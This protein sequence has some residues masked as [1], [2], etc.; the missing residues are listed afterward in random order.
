METDTAAP[1]QA[2]QTD[3]STAE[4]NIS[5][6][7]PKL[8][9]VDAK[10]SDTEGK[11]E[12]NLAIYQFQQAQDEAK[13]APQLNV[14]KWE[15]SP[16][17]QNAKLSKTGMAM[18]FALLVASL[19]GPL[20]MRT[21]AK[22]AM[23]A[24]TAAIKGWTEGDKEKWETARSDYD[25]HLKFIEDQNKQLVAAEKQIRADKALNYHEKDTQ[26]RLLLLSYGVDRRQLDGDIKKQFSVIQNAHNK[27]FAAS[28]KELKQ[29]NDQLSDKALADK[30]GREPTSEEKLKARQAYKTEG[31][32][33][34]VAK[35]GDA[36]IAGQQPPEI[37][38]FG[39]AKIAAPLKAYLADKGYDQKQALLDYGAQKKFLSTL[40]GQQQLR[41]RQ[42]ITFTTDSLGIVE[43]LAKQWDGGN[44]PLLNRANLIAA[45]NGAMGPE[46]QKVATKLD[47]QIADLTS[48]LGT[49]YKGGNS[50]TD[51][52][53]RL[54]A[55]NLNGAWSKGQLLENVALI[56]K[57][58]TIR[59]NSIETSGVVGTSAEKAKQGAIPTTAEEAQAAGWTKAGKYKKDPT[60]DVWR[61]KD[62]K[63]HIF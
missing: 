38:G 33:G 39:M 20:F 18:G 42:A 49:V 9:E 46:A 21:G 30:L 29:S 28:T 12:S 36:I 6:L 10:I 37:S 48:E 41:L 4:T 45:K 54:A 23:S 47:T 7:Q 31:L 26:L 62:G 61:D 40:N 25:R 15:N 51:E 5:T 34:Q 53:L 50:S 11:V 27:L 52:S 55:Q 13:T 22:G 44:F 59:K 57:N 14:P 1:E 35:I 60:K 3:I 58:L 32:Q 17:Y 19:V 43:D 2:L 63:P 8:D 56:R 24:L 16:E